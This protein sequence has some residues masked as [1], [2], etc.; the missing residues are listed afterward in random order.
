[1]LKDGLLREEIDM[2]DKN[3]P[4]KIAR[5]ECTY[6]GSIAFVPHMHEELEFLY[7]ISGELMVQ[8][9][10]TELHAQGG[11]VVVINSGDLHRGVAVSK[12]PSWYC[13][14]VHPSLIHSSFLDAC[15]TKYITPITQKMILFENILRSDSEVKDCIL[16]IV[17][18]HE[19]K[20][21]AFEL[22]IKASIYKLLALLIR[23]HVQ[24]VLSPAQYNLRLRNLE[25]L[26]TVLQYIDDN[27][28]NKI[29]ID[30][31]CKLTNLNRFYFCR[32]FKE[33]TGKS[34]TEYVN[35]IRIN[36]AEYLLKNTDINVTEAALNTGFN[37]L[38]YFSRLFR[39]YKNISPSQL[40]AS[41]EENLCN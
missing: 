9:N 38:N 37:D 34:P 35:Y 40:K 30:M 5:Y 10:S 16:K 33:I 13:L 23:K 7:L 24:T 22:S 15:D 21:P 27:Y 19:R 36:K 20:E 29:T 4:I 6:V 18:E 26:K 28:S 41:N 1:M 17:Q 39:R 2:P 11:D 31:L 12:N 3:F 8:C 25:R 14:I 32:L